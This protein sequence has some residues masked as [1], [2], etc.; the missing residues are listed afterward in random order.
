MEFQEKCLIC[1]TGLSGSGKTTAKKI[2]ES[3]GVKTFYTK[4]F[5]HL[6]NQNLYTD[7]MSGTLFSTEKAGFIKKI[8]E[9]IRCYSI[10]NDLILLDSIRSTDELNYLK[11]LNFKSVTLVKTHTQEKERLQ[12]LISRDNCSLSDIEKRDDIDSGKNPIYGFNIFEVF[13]FSDYL[14]DMT[15]PLSEVYH[16]ISSIIVSVKGLSQNRHLISFSS[17]EAS[18]PSQAT[19]A[20]FFISLK[21]R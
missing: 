21:Q 20:S 12:R 11:S 1:L 19:P 13:K 17:E 6:M 5:H 3:F 7:K 4:D 14:L 10:P 15:K 16:Q 18:R 8:I 2:F 9:N